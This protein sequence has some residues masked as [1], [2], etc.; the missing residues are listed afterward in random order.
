MMITFMP[1][2]VLE[3][4]DGVVVVP[5]HRHTLG[6]AALHCLAH[7]L[8]AFPQH[9]GDA[10]AIP[11]IHPFPGG[12]LAGKLPCVLGEDGQAHEVNMGE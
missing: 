11:Q 4:Q 1:N 3:Q 10:L 5:I 9:L 12:H 6:D 7:S 2:Q 8:R